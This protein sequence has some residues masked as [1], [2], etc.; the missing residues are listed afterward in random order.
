MRGRCYVK[1]ERKE[2]GV[3]RNGAVACGVG[4]GRENEE[5]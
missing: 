1:G 2:E 5:G 4:E 3:D